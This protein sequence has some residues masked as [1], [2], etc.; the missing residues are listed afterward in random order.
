M[1]LGLLFRDKYHMKQRVTLLLSL[2]SLTPFSPLCT[3]LLLCLQDNLSEQKL[4]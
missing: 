3:A 4:D 2:L 1:K